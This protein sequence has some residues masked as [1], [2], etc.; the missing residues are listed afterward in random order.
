MQSEQ[1]PKLTIQKM[2]EVSCAHLDPM[3][4]P[5]NTSLKVETK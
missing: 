3:L 4:H 5:D 1:I 2:Q